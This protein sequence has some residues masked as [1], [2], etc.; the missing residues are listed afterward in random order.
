MNT[1][2]L[3]L[4]FLKLPEVAAGVRVEGISYRSSIHSVK[5]GRSVKIPSCCRNIQDELSGGLR[6]TFKGDLL[7]QVAA[8]RDVSL[9]V[10][11]QPSK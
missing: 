4:L 3:F 9:V 5:Q 7:D 6:Y 10:P 8:F 1:H 11:V 2:L